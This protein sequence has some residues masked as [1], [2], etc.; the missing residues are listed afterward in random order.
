MNIDVFVMAAGQSSRFGS[1]KQLQLVNGK[2]MFL[3]VIER[4]EHP[5]IARKVLV[6]GAYH[7]EMQRLSTAAHEYLEAK[8]WHQ[9]LSA[10]I[11][12][13]V[14]HIDENASHL[15]IAL[16]D[17]IAIKADAFK[18]LIDAAVDNPS[19]I[20]AAKYQGMKAVP[21]IFP[22]HHLALLQSL[23]GDKGA[24]SILNSDRDVIAVEMPSAALDIDTQ[25]D[26]N[27]YLLTYD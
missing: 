23:N 17:Q 12:T 10:S 3:H 9:G 24:G 8:N 4:I 21:A 16:A 5:S 22:K 13:A 20:V 6:T 26:L 25:E 1:P 15:M 18:L 11:L 7:V 2:P 14:E 19:S 27:Q